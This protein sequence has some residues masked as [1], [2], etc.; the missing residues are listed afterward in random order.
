MAVSSA[1]IA[2]PIQRGVARLFEQCE[3]ARLF[4]VVIGGERVFQP[5][6]CHHDERTA[7]GQAPGLVGVTGEKREAGVQ[8]PEIMTNPVPETALD[9]E[10]IF[11]RGGRNPGDE[12]FA[13]FKCPSCG[14]V[15]LLDYEVTG[16]RKT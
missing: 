12:D 15:Y 4:E 8:T 11:A 5:M 1:S 2:T 16:E 13:L 7:V 3:K 14:Q 6:L 10:E 9:Y